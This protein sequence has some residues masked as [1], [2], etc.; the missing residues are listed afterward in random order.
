M[1]CHL[2]PAVDRFKAIPEPEKRAEFRDKLA[3]YVGL[4]AFLSQIVPYPDPELEMLYSYGRY[5]LPPLP[6]DRDNTV[7]KL[8]DEVALAYY[9]LERVYSGGIELK[10]IGRASCRERV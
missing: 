8:G 2:Q 7:L 5:L 9:R 1:Q 10:E 6:L 4:Y 3:A